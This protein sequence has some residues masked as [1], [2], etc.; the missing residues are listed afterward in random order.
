[1]EYLNFDVEITT[2]TGRVYPVR[3]IE[4]PAGE[5]RET[6][7][8]PFGELEL[9]NKLQ[10]LQIALLSSGGRYR[11]ILPPEQQT[12]K[13]F[14]QALFDA[15]LTNEV[16]ARYDVSLREAT[17][18]GK[19][20]RLKLRISS[21]DL[22][23]LPW[24]FMYDSR[25]G[26]YV[27]LSRKTPVVRYPEL[28]QP[29]HLLEGVKPPLHILGMT[30]SPNGLPSLDTAVE[31]QI[32]ETAL[33]D[34]RET[35]KV[36]LTWLSGQTWRH[37]QRAMRVKR[38]HVF[39]FIGHGGFDCVTDEGFIALTDEQNEICRL[40][41]TELARLLVNHNLRLVLLNACEGA[42]GSTLS[43]FSSTASILL[44][45]GLPAVVA[46]QYPI[47]NRAAI[48]FA[49]AFYESLAD[50]LSM[51]A[52]MVEARVAVSIA[53]KNT[54]EW[55]TPVLYT[56]VPDE[57]LLTLSP[58]SEND[59]GGWNRAANAEYPT[60]SSR[61]D[62]TTR[63]KI[64]QAY[65]TLQ[66]EHLPP[67]S[68]KYLD[69]AK[70]YQKLGDFFTAG[71]CISRARK[72]RDRLYVEH[73]DEGGYLTGQRVMQSQAHENGLLHAICHTFVIVN[74]KNIYLQKRVASK[75][76]NPNKWT[77]SSCGHVIAGELPYEA[78]QRE[79]YEELGLS[80]TEQMEMEEIGYT[81][82]LSK[83][84][85]N[86]RCN[87]IAYI[88]CVNVADE[89]KLLINRREIAELKIMAI[90]EVDAMLKGEGKALEFA[91]NFAPI[92]SHLWD[93]WLSKQRRM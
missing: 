16:R 17:S 50:G 60:S 65:E 38:W 87:A 24:E 41:A 10:A 63:P 8:F 84:P 54:I 89:P 71:E 48:E 44:Q 47:T 15:L 13:D 22:A 42:L 5:A 91:D 55:G 18:Q 83:G 27:C 19:G 40:N 6:M 20:L 14:G 70:V 69:L 76:M 66:K 72:E 90:E 68:Q 12:V 53:V 45:Q 88:F 28:P 3:V 74:R 58:E 37:L 29:S 34:L 59:I 80:L 92:F 57:A 75:T 73:L 39:H 79:L 26:E 30:A 25:Q 2:G 77:S 93:W 56:H 64:K 61:G 11:K 85:E 31:K 51:D 81:S 4:S 9:E 52:A 33:Q 82:V 62:I 32:I 43:L 78:A 1:M 36:E 49:R 7:Q 23:A 67:E 46:M 35:G 86:H 21:P